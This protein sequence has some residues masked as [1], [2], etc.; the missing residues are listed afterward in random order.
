MNYIS[1]LFIISLTCAH[2]VTMQSADIRHPED[3]RSTVVNNR[4]SITNNSSKDVTIDLFRGE[5]RGQGRDADTKPMLNYKA[6]AT[7][8][9][10]IHRVIKPTGSFMIPN[11]ESSEALVV[12]NSALSIESEKLSNHDCIIPI[13][14]GTVWGIKPKQ[15]TCTE[16]P[17]AIFVTQLEMER[18]RKLNTIPGL[19]AALGISPTAPIDDY[20]ILGLARDA[21]HEQVRDA[22][23]NLTIKW[24]P[25][26]AENKALAHEVTSIVREAYERLEASHSELGSFG[27]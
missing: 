17:H 4:L 12:N 25:D 19:R 18:Y 21:S 3:I 2:A 24:H 9:L 22:Y 26:R 7:R 23:K 16:L 20:A 15:M 13:V 14:D 8:T 11:F 6:P 1:N 27:L 5:T 10:V